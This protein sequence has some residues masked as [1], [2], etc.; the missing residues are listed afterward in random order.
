MA[1]FLDRCLKSIVNQSYKT[2]EI[3][4]VDDGS[5]D[6][7][8][9]ICLSYAEK[10]KRI[11]Y[12]YKQNG[13]L[14]SARNYGIKFSHGKYIMFIDS[15]DYVSEN[16]CQEA[17]RAVKKN[18]ADIGIFDYTVVNNS[19]SS[20]VVHVLNSS[21]G[22][23][24]MEKAMSCLPKYS[25]AWNKIYK[26]ELFQTV[27][28]P[29][30]KNYEDA[31]TTFKLFNNSIRICYLPKS[32]YF[33]VKRESSITSQLSLKNIKDSFEA[34]YILYTFLKS[35]Y[36]S[37]ANDQFENVVYTAIDY[38]CYFHEYDTDRDEAKK[39]LLNESVPQTVSKKLKLLINLYRISPAIV[40]NLYK[41][42]LQI[43]YGL[44]V[45]K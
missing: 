18:K 11:V 7:S 36:Q 39:F 3:I 19:K 16:F 21:K 33:Y 42:Y 12:L 38:C 43:R 20:E 30:G 17:M 22:L 5:T 25:Y 4:L 6:I 31:R 9:N 14:S 29:N 1:P 40:E 24:T 32:L 37:I 2:I 45:K 44:K 13:G 23:Q 34:A 27:R 10:D 35:K 8:K 28:Y 15:D 26:R 41:F